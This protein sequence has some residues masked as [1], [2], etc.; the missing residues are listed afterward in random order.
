VKPSKLAAHRRNYEHAPRARWLIEA[1][2]DG[3]LDHRGREGED[4]AD[5]Y[6]LLTTQQAAARLRGDEVIRFHR[7]RGDEVI[8]C[9]HLDLVTGSTDDHRLRRESET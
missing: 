4:Y 7:L 1:H 6:D 2:S 3:S 9:W 8:D 5:D